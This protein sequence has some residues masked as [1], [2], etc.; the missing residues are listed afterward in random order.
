MHVP[1]DLR[2]YF[3]FTFIRCFAL[4]DY[5]GTEQPFASSAKPY[6]VEWYLDMAVAIKEA[7]WVIPEV[8]MAACAEC[9]ASRS[10]S[11]DSAA[12]SE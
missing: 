8:Q 9:A 3:E 1:Q 12:H 10:L 4:C 6:S 11:H 2:A 7:N 5:C